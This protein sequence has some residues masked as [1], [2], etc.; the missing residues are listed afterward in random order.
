METLYDKI[1]TKLKTGIFDD[2]TGAIYYIPRNMANNRISTRYNLHCKHTQ[3][4]LFILFLPR[5]NV[6]RRAVRIYIS[7]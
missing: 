1:K 5:K 2:L 3:F 7:A 4:N 6:L